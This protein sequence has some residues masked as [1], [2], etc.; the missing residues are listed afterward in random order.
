MKTFV[1]NLKIGQKVWAT[2]EEI[3]SKEAF[4]VNF[5]GDLLRISNMVGKNFRAG[6][7]VQLNVY[8]LK[9]LHFQLVEP[10]R[11]RFGLDLDV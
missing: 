8:A 11:V 7:R 1:N 10:K 3:I 4:I 5:D 6:Q 2:I 9:P